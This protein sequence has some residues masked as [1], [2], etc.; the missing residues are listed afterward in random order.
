VSGAPLRVAFAGTPPFAAA[1]LEAI[2]ASGNDVVLVL[3]QPDR[4]AGRGMRLTASAVSEA[5][6]RD[7]IA[8][9]KPASLRDE[10]IQ[11]AL[12]TADLDVMV[13]AAYGLLLPQALL[14]IPR[15]GCLNIHA[16]LL[17]RWRGAAP[18]Q[19]AILAGDRQTGVS[20]MQMEAG[21][22]TGPVLLAEPI[23][24]DAASTT[25]T[26]TDALARL[27]ARLIVS[28]LKEFDS[29]RAVPQ[30]PAL[31]THAPKIAKA[32]HAIDWTRERLHRTPG[33]RTQPRAWSGDPPGLRGRQD[34]G[35]GR[36]P[37]SG[38]AGEIIVTRSL[39]W[40]GHGAIALRRVQR[41][42]GKPV[43]G[44]ELAR[45]L[46][47]TTGSRFGPQLSPPAKTLK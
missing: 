22:D 42:G 13:V 31:A 30:D 3:T 18:I 32:E 29:L 17:P 8:V 39:W 27:G 16:S 34:P 20:I 10:S 25:G 37:L 26:L 19:R 44:A 7:A 2:R 12:R 41:A 4:P 14:D 6:A 9:L 45:G 46:R 24:I 11:E 40:H 15:R 1:A 28:A 35:G 36:E 21:L 38:G 33:T 23:G 5:A 43:S 47:L